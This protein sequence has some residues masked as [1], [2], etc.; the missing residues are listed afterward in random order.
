MARED[1][2][3]AEFPKIHMQSRKKQN[4]ERKRK[5]QRIEMKSR[6]EDVGIEVREHA[7]A[8]Q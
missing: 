8:Y 3:E 4:Q 5:E 1:D 6:E 7:E 2:R